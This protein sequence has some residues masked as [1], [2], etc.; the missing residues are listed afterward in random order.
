M[1]FSII[2]ALNEN[3][4]IGFEGKLPWYCKEELELFKKETLNSVLIVG[5]KTFTSLPKLS[6][7]DII[8][9]SRH[10]SLTVSENP[11]IYQKTVGSA[12]V[13]AQARFPGKKIFVA[14]GENI[15]K[16]ALDIVYKNIIPFEKLQISFMKNN[17]PCDVFFP[18]LAWEDWIVEDE[19][20]HKD[21]VSR[22]FR[23]APVNVGERQYITLLSDVL[24]HGESRE[25]RNGET[26]SVFSRNLTFDLREGFPL[27]T[28]KKMFFKG[29]VEELL[30]FIRGETD[31]KILEEKGINIWKGNTSKQ[32]LNSLGKVERR[33]GIMGPMYGYNWRFFGSKY[34]EKTARPTEPGIDQLQNV[35][36]LLRT[37]PHSRR[38]IM[39][40]YNP[41]Q[42]EEGVLFPC[43]SLIVQFYVSET[44]LD[45]SCYNRSQDLFLGT[46]FNIA[47]SALLL[48]LVAKVTGFTPR[49]LCM[50]LGDVHIY[51]QHYSLAELQTK[52]FRYKFPEIRVHKEIKE[53]QDI[54]RL[55]FEDFVLDF[56]KSHPGIKAEMVA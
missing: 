44:N 45:M 10:N 42:A 37:D 43:H 48:F 25:T 27:L 16:E 29:I 40:D 54:E 26:K 4:G 49:N 20:E 28:T 24:L 6:D 15:Y 9:V 12:I 38:I 14:G 13:T 2:V 23:Y 17:N 51:K 52:R 53:I 7:R 55:N 31:T 18:E 21:F 19:K 34:D 50:N 47:S 3:R 39:T 30:F 5:R 33:E 11:C 1:K 35:I 41:L 22:T 46:P 8:C 32:F 56:Y 36:T